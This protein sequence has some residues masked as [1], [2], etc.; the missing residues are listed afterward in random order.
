MEHT[1]AKPFSWLL[2]V[3]GAA[4]NESSQRVRV[5]RALKTLGVAVI[6]DGIYLAPNLSGIAAELERHQQAINDAGGS[7]FIFTATHH[8]DDDDELFTLFDRT[9][10]Y[11]T[12]IASGQAVIANLRNLAETD[13]RKQVRQLRRE[14]EGLAAT[15]YFPTSAKNRTQA[16]LIEAERTYADLFSPGE[17]QAAQTGIERLN[18]AAFQG[19]VWATRAKPWV[20]RVAS[21]W[22]IRRFIDPEAHFLWLQHVKD[23]PPNALGFDFDGAT[24]T[25]VGDFSTF[26]T[27]LHSFGLNNDQALL[28]L[29][30]TVHYLD[31]GG[32]WTAEAGGFEAMLTGL[33]ERDLNDDAFLVEACMLVELLYVSY[34][35]RQAHG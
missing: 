24:F 10:A 22:L 14:Y 29:A 18:P 35:Q 13:A 7:A 17:P 8:G 6:R 27:L 15:D 26:E 16:M 4:A 19:R 12:L 11:E 23:C 5:W 34:R 31:I 20:D 33:R 32:T 2:L 1:P 21:A 9:P 25:H 28:K 30:A 3:M